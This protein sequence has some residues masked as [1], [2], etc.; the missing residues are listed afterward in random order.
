MAPKYPNSRD[1]SSIAL[2][3]LSG[4]VDYR[5]CF[6]GRFSTTPA[7]RMSRIVCMFWVRAARP[8]SLPARVIFIGVWES[9]QHPFFVCGFVL[10]FV[11]GFTTLPTLFFLTGVLCAEGGLQFRLRDAVCVSPGEGINAEGGKQALVAADFSSTVP[12]GRGSAAPRVYSRNRSHM[13][14]IFSSEGGG[15]R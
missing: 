5:H 1:K 9:L 15:S 11:P 3:F 10:R 8:W 6:Q 4:S 14:E 13:A 2:I 12:P 7:T